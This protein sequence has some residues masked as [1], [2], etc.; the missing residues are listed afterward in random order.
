MLLIGLLGLL[1]TSASKALSDTMTFS[2]NLAMMSNMVQF[3]YGTTVANRGHMESHWRKWGPFYLITLASVASMAD[4]FRQVLIDGRSLPPH[5]FALMGPDGV[6]V[7]FDM[8][9]YSYMAVATP[10]DPGAVAPAPTPVT[11]VGPFGGGS[12]AV[13]LSSP[14]HSAC[15]YLSWAGVFLTMAGFSWLADVVTSVRR[16]SKGEPQLSCADRANAV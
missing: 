16:W 4:L 13:L 5:S 12:W 14:V 3:V 8:A 10:L 6:P 9:A 1:A 11:Q 7:P 15:Y 2:I